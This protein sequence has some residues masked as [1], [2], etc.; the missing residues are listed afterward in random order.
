MIQ[1]EHDLRNQTIVRLALQAA[2]AARTAPK[3]KGIDCLEIALVTG[4]EIKQLA[5]RMSEISVKQVDRIFFSRDAD[6]IMH[7]ETVLLIG[8]SLMSAGLNCGYCGFSSCIEKDA[9]ENIPCFFNVHDLGLAIGS[10]VS[11]AADVRVDTRVM[12][13]VGWAAKDLN[14]MPGCKWILGIPFSASGKSPFF[15]RK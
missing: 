5:D 10:A 7:A 8:S 2:T 14:F 4:E 1:F 12:F 13:S 6:N 9:H 15:D 11:K 3:A